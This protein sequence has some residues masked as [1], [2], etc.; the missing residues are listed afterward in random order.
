M[1]MAVFTAVYIATTYNV[2]LGG[3]PVGVGV[4]TCG[5]VKAIS[6]IRYYDQGKAV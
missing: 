5:I 6:N 3:I 4:F 1:I 2:W